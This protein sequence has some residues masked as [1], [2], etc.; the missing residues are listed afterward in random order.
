MDAFLEEPSSYLLDTR[1]TH[2][3]DKLEDKS[4]LIALQIQGI[5]WARVK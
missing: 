4:S 2:W 1:E 3:R 5:M